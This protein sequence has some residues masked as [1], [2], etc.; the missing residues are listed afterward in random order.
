[1][2]YLSRGHAKITNVIFACREY[3]QVLH[4]GPVKLDSVLL[5]FSRENLIVLEP[6]FPSAVTYFCMLILRFGCTFSFVIKLTW[7]SEARGFNMFF[8]G[9]E[10]ASIWILTP[11]L[12]LVFN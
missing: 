4:F 12:E 6:H 3:V 1:M 10:T 11:L 8:C 5:S 9:I 2:K 7:F